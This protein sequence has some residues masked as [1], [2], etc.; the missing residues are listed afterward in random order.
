MNS[1]EM[2]KLINHVWTAVMLVVL[3]IACQNLP[4]NQG[5]PQ[6]GQNESSFNNLISLNLGK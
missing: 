6:N 4:E 5:Q 3:L 2:K 1:G